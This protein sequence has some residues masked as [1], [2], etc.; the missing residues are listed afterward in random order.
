MLSGTQDFDPGNT[1]GSILQF[2][3]LAIQFGGDEPIVSCLSFALR[4]NEIAFVRGPSGIG[5]SR[6]LRAIAELEPS[7]VRTPGFFLQ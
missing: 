4:A 6:L 7:H 1:T 5:K 2:N 3:N